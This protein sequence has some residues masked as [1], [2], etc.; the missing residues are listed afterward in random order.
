MVPLPSAVI[1]PPAVWVIKSAARML[2]FP[3]EPVLVLTVAFRAIPATVAVVVSPAFKR[4][5]PPALI[6]PLLAAV[7]IPP[8]RV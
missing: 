2:I 6:S 8:L 7:A 5:F 4:I 3:A 1:S